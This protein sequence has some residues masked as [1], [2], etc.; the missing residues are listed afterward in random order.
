MSN[1]LD[2]KYGIWYRI[3]GKG[4]NAEQIHRYMFNKGYPVNKS[5]TRE[6]LIEELKKWE[7]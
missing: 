1:N 2:Y 5:M 7:K 6:E 3:K 4:W